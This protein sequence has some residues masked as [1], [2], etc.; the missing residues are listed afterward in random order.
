MLRHAFFEAQQR[1]PTTSERCEEHLSAHRF[2]ARRPGPRGPRGPSKTQAVQAAEKV[3]C[4]KGMMALKNS[5]FFRVFMYNYTTIICYYTILYNI[6]H[7]F[8]IV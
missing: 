3:E 5:Q 6:I 7:M 2:E 1:P 8:N 4:F